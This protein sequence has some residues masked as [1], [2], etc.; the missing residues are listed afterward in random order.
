M[1]HPL[2]PKRTQIT[3]NNKHIILLLWLPFTCTDRGA[4]CVSQLLSPFAASLF[5]LCRPREFWADR[6]FWAEHCCAIV[7]WSLGR[8]PRIYHGVLFEDF[9]VYSAF[10]DALLWLDK[11][12]WLVLPLVLVLFLL[13]VSLGMAWW[14]SLLPRNKSTQTDSKV[15][16]HMLFMQTHLFLDCSY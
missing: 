8:S 6:S 11:W 10:I 4:L 12:F 9:G 2:T 14:L 16:T 3:N 15:W 7:A 5:D 1:N 13:F